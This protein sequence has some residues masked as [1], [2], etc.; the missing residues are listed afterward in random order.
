MRNN[1]QRWNTLP[2]SRCT[3]H[4][5]QTP[6]PH[7]FLMSIS[8]LYLTFVAL[9]VLFIHAY[10][11]FHACL[12]LVNL[13]SICFRVLRLLNSNLHLHP[14]PTPIPEMY[15]LG[16]GWI[17]GCYSCNSHHVGGL[18]PMTCYNNGCL[19]H[20]HT[21]VYVSQIGLW[22]PVQFCIQL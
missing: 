4:K 12:I 9:F 6:E 19:L 1:N 2:M 20:Y 15:M 16:P 3:S 14:P 7:S 11:C 13:L 22:S 5:S 21:V 8:N 17:W 10:V 18:W